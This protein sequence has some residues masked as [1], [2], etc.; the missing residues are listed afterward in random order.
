VITR[1]K[2]YFRSMK[3][4]LNLVLISSLLIL[5]SCSGSRYSYL[6]TRHRVHHTHKTSEVNSKKDKN[7][8]FGL[9]SKTLESKEKSCTDNTTLTESMGLVENTNVL[10]QK[11][12]IKKNTLPIFIQTKSETKHVK[13]SIKE[14]KREGV[15]AEAGNDN[16]TFIVLGILVLVGF[17]LLL[18][19]LGVSIG[20]ILLLVL[21]AILFGGL[22]ALI[23]A[24]VTD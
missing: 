7:K 16:G 19:W 10:L 9:R 24:S 15:K 22:I 18:N 14:F 4:L 8:D 5:A 20:G 21:L 12:A 11:N 3:R 23:L 2:G 6:T 17:F 13:K 1:F